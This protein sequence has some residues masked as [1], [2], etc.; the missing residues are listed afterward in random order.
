MVVPPAQNL[1]DAALAQL[2]RAVA[3]GNAEALRSVY[4]SEKNRLFGLILRF[5]RSREL[6]ED[7][8]TDT[9]VK[10]WT[11]ADS[12]DPGKGQAAS[13]LTTVAR[14]QAIDSLRAR[15][16]DRLVAREQSFEDGLPA[17]DHD[18]C[19]LQA[20][21]E[22]AQ[23][24]RQ[25]VNDLSDPERAAIQAVFFQGLTHSQAAL[26]LNAPLG[27]L[28]SRVRCALER[29]RDRLPNYEEGAA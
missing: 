1:T 8:L 27:T 11:K 10:V 15:G 23:L 6:A 24:V 14:R 21:A 25:A 2:L 5:V 19:D 28:K 20:S 26:S 29:M 4:E 18:P 17:A 13:W 22:H 16:R 9:F 3:Q 12:F 7:V